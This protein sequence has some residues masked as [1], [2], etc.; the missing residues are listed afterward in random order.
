MHEVL[1][2]TGWDMACEWGETQTEGGGCCDV[3]YMRVSI[4]F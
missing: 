2:P 1:V 4:V 3:I